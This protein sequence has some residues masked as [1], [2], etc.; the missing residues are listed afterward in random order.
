M[1]Q[2]PSLGREF[3]DLSE[4]SIL[5]QQARHVAVLGAHWQ[6]YKPAYY[7]PAYLSSMGYQ[8]YPINPT[9]TNRVLCGSPV[10]STLTELSAALQVKQI[11]IDVVNIFRQSSALV[12]HIEEILSMQPLPKCV[13]LQLG[14]KRR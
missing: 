9:L 11:Q 7:V 1:T 14:I 6:E 13:W 12:G 5:L 4:T 8:I 3:Y 10:Y 2:S